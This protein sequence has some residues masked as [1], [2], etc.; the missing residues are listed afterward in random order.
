VTTFDVLWECLPGFGFLGVGV[1]LLLTALVPSW[2][3][4]GWTHWQKFSS[5]NSCLP[6]KEGDLDVST[7]VWVYLALG[8]CVSLFGIVLIIT[9]VRASIG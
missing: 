6:I 1:Y 8:I 2:R 3:E 5:L 7:A 9:V 4:K